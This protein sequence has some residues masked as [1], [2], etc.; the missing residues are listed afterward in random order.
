[1][2][3]IRHTPGFWRAG[4]WTCHA[5]TTVLVN[6]PSVLTGYR[7]I[8]EFETEEDARLGAAVP[9]L[10]EAAILAEAVLARGRWIEGSTDPEAVALWKLR[11]ALAKAMEARHHG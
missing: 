1:M 8:A 9:E 6:D 2:A 5:A 11:A 4:K 10:I 7:V 3:E